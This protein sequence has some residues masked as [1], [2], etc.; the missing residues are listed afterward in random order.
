MKYFFSFKR[1]CMLDFLYKITIIISLKI[2]K[3]MKQVIINLTEEQAKFLVGT[4]ATHKTTYA[5]NRD[6]AGEKRNMYEFVIEQYDKMI[7]LLSSNDTVNI[8]LSQFGSDCTTGMIAD[9][10]SELACKLFYLHPGSGVIK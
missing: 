5:I 2:I 3:K 1:N 7:S 10:I 4:I 8:D 6:N 9:S